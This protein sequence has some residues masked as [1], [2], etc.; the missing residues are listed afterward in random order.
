M[1]NPKPQSRA[2]R[3]A[4]H[5]CSGHPRVVDLVHR[6]AGDAPQVDRA[7][8]PR[9]VH[10]CHHRFPVHSQLG[11]HTSRRGG[12][13]SARPGAVFRPPEIRPLWHGVAR[14]GRDR[15]GFRIWFQD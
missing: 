13:D 10:P 3:E 4:L 7:D 8:H 15:R 5:A 9:V 2:P 1:V 11:R 12:L 14:A 6:L